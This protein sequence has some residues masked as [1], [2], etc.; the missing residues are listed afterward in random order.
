MTVHDSEMARRIER[1]AA[2]DMIGSAAGPE[3][4]ALAATAAR[5]VGTPIAA[6]TMIDA[7]TQHVAA[8]FGI[9]AAPM[10]REESFCD[11]TIRGGEVLIVPDAS[12]DGRFASLPIVVDTPLIRFYA[13]VPIHVRVDD[14]RTAIGA[15]CVLDRVPRGLS[16]DAR[17]ALIDLAGIAEAMI[18]ARGAARRAV[19]L[20]TEAN[21]RS[22]A[23]S[24]QQHIFRQAER[25]AMIGGWRYEP[26]TGVL[27]WS[28]GVRRIHDVDADFVPGLSNALDFYPPAA[29][30]VVS[31]SLARALETGDPFDFETDLVTARGRQLRVRG[32]GEVECADG[33]VTAMTGV[34][35]D[36]TARWLMEQQLR[37]SA[38]LDALTGI[39]NRAGFDQTLSD[40]LNRAR[41]S[42][43]ALALVLIDLDGF[44]R[45]NDSH[46]HVIG[47]DVL[48]AYGFRLRADWLADAYSARLGGDEFAL[49][50]E[51]PATRDL[52]R[53]IDRLLPHLARPIAVEVET[54]VVPGTIGWARLVPGMECVRDLVHAADTALYQAKRDRRGTARAASA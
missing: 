2:L 28:E 34:F 37:R 23:L 41:A 16:D 15:L 45:V 39:A 32:R 17:A 36:V 22:I 3:F 31:D 44:K 48:R 4:D 8:S 38:H 33:T 40:A 54:L 14:E 51:G 26:A 9:P 47:D 30:A 18:E 1:L 10:P 6:V 13:G 52:P 43:G 19:E 27:E 49:I 5:I 35:Q 21:D 12:R 20:A 25:L 29:R 50:L 42:D 53:R 7:D 11:H 46:G 24:R